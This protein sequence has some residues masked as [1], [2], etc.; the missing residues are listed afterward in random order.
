MHKKMQTKIDLK[1]SN[2]ALSQYKSQ[3]IKLDPKLVA[4]L[5]NQASQAYIEVLQKQIAEIQVNRDLACS[6]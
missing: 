5:E 1:T 3:I 6:K 4:Y 2:E